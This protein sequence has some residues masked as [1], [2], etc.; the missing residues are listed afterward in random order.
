MKVVN[1]E[2]GSVERIFDF[3]LSSECGPAHSP[4]G[5]GGSD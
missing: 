2:A 5:M 3:L 4:I 1:E